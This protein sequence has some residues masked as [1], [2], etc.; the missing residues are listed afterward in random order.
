[1]GTPIAVGKTWLSLD[2]Q[3]YSS[4]TGH[5]VVESKR[6]ALH[7][8]GRMVYVRVGRISTIDLAHLAVFALL[9]PP[10]VGMHHKRSLL[11]YCFLKLSYVRYT[12]IVNSE[13]VVNP[14]RH[15]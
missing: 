12:A 5:H 10:R 11:I 14:P 7:V 15:G 2:V 6:R 3:Q 13:R 1:M 9:S 8:V 4:R